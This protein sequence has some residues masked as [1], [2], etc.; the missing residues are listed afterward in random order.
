MRMPAY[1]GST[2]PTHNVPWLSA[3]DQH[4]LK[5]GQ[6]SDRAMLHVLQSVQEANVRGEARR[7][8]SFRDIDVDRLVTST[9]ACSGSPA[10]WATPTTSCRFIG[11][12]GEEPEITLSELDQLRVLEHDQYEVV[13]GQ[14]D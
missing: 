3:T 9:K 2:V 6:A 1:G 10:P 7:L 8:I 5:G 13:R 14:V 11:K 4:G 12:D